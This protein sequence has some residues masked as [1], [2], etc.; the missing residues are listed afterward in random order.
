MQNF[1]V[2]LQRRSP[3][4][5]TRLLAQAVLQGDLDGL[6]CLMDRLLETGVTP[7]QSLRVGQCYLLRTTR[8]GCYT[9]RVKA[10]SFTDVVLSEAAWLPD[11]D[12]VGDALRTGQLEIVDPFPDEVIIS[13]AILID[14]APWPHPLPREVRRYEVAGPF[15]DSS[16]IPF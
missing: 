15:E 2:E 8:H 16:D 4:E 13:T 3:D 5:T 6:P 10:V 12:S 7:M 11:Q 9:G 14:A 1:L